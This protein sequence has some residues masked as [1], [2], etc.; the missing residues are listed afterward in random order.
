MGA[1]KHHLLNNAVF[2]FFAL[3]VFSSSFSIALSQASFGISLLLF[4]ILAVTTRY[5]PFA[6]RLLCIYSVIGLYLVWMIVSTLVNDSSLWNL[7]EE[8]LFSIIPV[9]LFLFKQQ[10]FRRIIVVSLALGVILAST[11]GIIQHYTGVNW[12]KDYPPTPAHDGTFYA[13][14]GFHHNL[15]YGNYLAVAAMFV[16]SLGILKKTRLLGSFNWLVHS[17]GI[18]GFMGTILSYS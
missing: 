11:Y 12:F 7:K 5:N 1:K 8:W 2:F 3:F 15:T 6:C 10:K 9:G 13:L 16:I 4:I 17:A 14:G 18:M